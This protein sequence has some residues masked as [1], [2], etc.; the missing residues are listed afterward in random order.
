MHVL[1]GGGSGFIGPALTQRFR[2][3]GDTV[4]WISRTASPGCITWQDVERGAVPSV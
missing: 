2:M 1:I 3:R 4:T